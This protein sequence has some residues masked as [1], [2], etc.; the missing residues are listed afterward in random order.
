MKLERR[1]QGDLRGSVNFLLSRGY[2][3]AR[4]GDQLILIRGQRRVLVADGRL[5][6]IGRGGVR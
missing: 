2:D 3:M 6:V 1:L 5:A 4:E